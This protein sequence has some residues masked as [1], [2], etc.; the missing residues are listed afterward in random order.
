MQHNL[1]DEFHFWMFP[2][3]VGSRQRL[4]D[5]RDTTHLKL[6]DQK[7]FRSGIVV[8]IYAPKQRYTQ[9][10][11]S[12]PEVPVCRNIQDTD[13]P[14]RHDCGMASVRTEILIG[15]RPWDVWDV[16]R[17]F[18]AVH[19]RL[20]PGFVVDAHLDDDARVVTFFNGAV[21]RE[22]LIDVD[23]DARRLVW[24]VVES[25]LNYRHHNASVQV[26]SDAEERTRFVW[27]ADML[28]NDIA[29]QVRE[30]QERAMSVVKA[31]AESRRDDP[32][33]HET[34]GR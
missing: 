8:L 11:V 17:D 7:T 16:V 2:V 20:V 1:V 24:S 26:F 6:V 9:S 25:P 19:E 18:G 14:S 4:R 3:A 33:D 23:D 34:V 32:S 28:P 21:A 12:S 29:P 15:A 30:L 5:G 27:I 10:P 22:L 31:V 13:R